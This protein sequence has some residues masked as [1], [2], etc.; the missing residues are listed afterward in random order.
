MTFL[1]NS[2][3][4]FFIILAA[5]AASQFRYESLCMSVSTFVLRLLM[6]LSF[7]ALFFWLAYRRDKRREEEHEGKKS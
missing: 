7:A 3:G 2:I 5:L 1:L 4:T 6:M